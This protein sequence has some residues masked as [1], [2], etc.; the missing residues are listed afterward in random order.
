L[1]SRQSV[2]QIARITARLLLTSRAAVLLYQGEE[3][4]QRTAVPQ[5]VEDVRD[6]MGVR[7]WPEDKGRDGARTP[8]PWTPGGPSAG[9]SASAET[10]LPVDPAHRPLAAAIQEG[11]ETN[12]TA[13]ADTVALEIDG[14]CCYNFKA[15][16]Q[17][18]G[19]GPCH[20][21]DGEGDVSDGRGG[22]A[23]MRFDRDACEDAD[24]ESVQE[25]DASTGDNFQSNQVTTV[26]FNDALSNVTIHGTGG[27]LEPLRN[28]ADPIALRNHVTAA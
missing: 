7:G 9:F 28:I 11:A 15:S 13:E 26:T 16:V 17:N 4:G 20:E 27:D 3:I 10:W 6:P 19:P 1:R 22:T 8:M 14:V 25:N 2:M 23:H 5:R 21:G 24:A 12:A 18:G